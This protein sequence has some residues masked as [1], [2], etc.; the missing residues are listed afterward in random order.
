[1]NIDKFKV[2][3]LGGGTGNVG[4]FIFDHL[5]NAEVECVEIDSGVIEVFNKNLNMLSVFK[6]CLL[7][8]WCTQ[9]YRKIQIHK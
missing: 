5:E 1:M 4:K 9:K 8:F 3:I 6:G 2:L 7:I